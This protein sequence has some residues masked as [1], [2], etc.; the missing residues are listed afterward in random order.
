MILRLRHD[1]RLPL[2]VPRRIRT[3][4]TQGDDVIGDRAGTRAR[5]PSSRAAVRAWKAITSLC[6]I[7]RARP[8]I[9]HLQATVESSQNG[10]SGEPDPGLLGPRR[11]AGAIHRSVMPDAANVETPRRRRS[12]AESIDIL[13]LISESSCVCSSQ[14]LR[15]CG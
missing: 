2:R 7:L 3:T 15:R 1:G 6:A 5:G 10:P 14:K 11:P 13:L 8:N 4:A 9:I 12:R